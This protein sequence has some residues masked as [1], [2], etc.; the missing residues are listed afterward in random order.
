MPQLE[1]ETFYGQLF[2]LAVVFIALYVVMWKL[3]LPNIGGVIETRGNKIQGDLSEAE[4]MKNQAEIF[5]NEQRSLMH[6]SGMQAQKLIEESSTKAKLAAEKK[7]VALMAELD[8][9][10]ADAESEISKTQSA[11]SRETKKMVQG[12]AEQIADKILKAA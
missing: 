8:K 10:L 6:S 3:V 2:W 7:R 4:K 9:K 5:A 12:L 1:F 11:A